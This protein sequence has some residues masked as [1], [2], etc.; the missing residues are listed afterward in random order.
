[1]FKAAL[2]FMISHPETELL[3]AGS[4]NWGCLFLPIIMEIHPAAECNFNSLM[5]IAQVPCDRIPNVLLCS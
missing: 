1:M 5:E 3:R 4:H 2:A